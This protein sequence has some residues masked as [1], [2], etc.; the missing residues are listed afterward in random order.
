MT[1]LILHLRAL[2]AVGQHRVRQEEVLN[3]TANRQQRVFVIPAGSGYTC[4]GFDN[5]FQH[6]KQLA[7]LLNR[8]DLAP[9][10]EEIGDLRQYEQYRALIQEASRRELGTYFEPGTPLEV[11]RVLEQYIANGKR[12]RLFYGD[13]TTGIDWLEEY[14]VIGR[15]GRS[16][17]PLRVPLL[18]PT[19][20]SY[21]GPA[22]LTSC[23]VRLID[24]ESR[25]EL[26]RHPTYDLPAFKIKTLRLNGKVE[27]AANGRAYAQ[28]ASRAQ[29]ERWIAFMRGESMR[30]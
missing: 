1:S 30:K 28:F 5:C 20:R 14:D 29:A 19:S 13:A 22:I 27:V 7:E 21:G 12:I 6:A 8:P 25:R 10:E 17:G 23:I 15:V 18:I 2:Y 16:M 11:R 26:Y 3:V 4:L 9:R 24:V